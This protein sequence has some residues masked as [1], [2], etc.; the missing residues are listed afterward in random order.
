M[1]TFS[2]TDACYVQRP[3]PPGTTLALMDY[4][5]T[6]RRA[7]NQRVVWDAKSAGF[8]G[9]P[10]VSPDNRGVIFTL[11][12]DPNFSGGGAFIVP[13]KQFG[14]RSELW[15]ADVDSGN[16]TVL[17]KAMGFDSPADI[18]DDS[19]SYLPFGSEELHQSY[20]PTISPVASGGYSGLLRFDSATRKT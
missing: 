5:A 10:F 7:S 2:R 16:A 17:A 1:P 19:K 12:S 11:T 9:W 6:A 14:P 8:V 4:D 18:D 13:V 3:W 15:M 20:Y